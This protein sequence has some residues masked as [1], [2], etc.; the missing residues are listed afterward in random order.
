MDLCSLLTTS[1]PHEKAALSKFYDPTSEILP[2]G[3]WDG[4]NFTT[5]CG[6]APASMVEFDQASKSHMLGSGVGEGP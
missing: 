5:G 3:L 4:V 2:V 1:N 6:E